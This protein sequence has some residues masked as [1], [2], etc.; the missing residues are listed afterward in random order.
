MPESYDVQVAHPRPQR[1]SMGTI[2]ELSKAADI[3]S[4]DVE[5]DDRFAGKGESP[6]P[7]RL[8]SPVKLVSDSVEGR[9]LEDQPS[10]G[11][12]ASG[13]EKI[14]NK[15]C[16][17]IKSSSPGRIGYHGKNGTTGKKKRQP[18]VLAPTGIRYPAPI[19]TKIRLPPLLSEQSKKASIEKLK[20]P[21]AI[22]EKPSSRPEEEF[23]ILS[24]P[25]ILA[26]PCEVKVEDK[27]EEKLVIEGDGISERIV[28][29][30]PGL[31]LRF[32]NPHQN[33]DSMLD[34]IPE[35][36][37]SAEEQIVQEAI[38]NP[39]SLLHELE[40]RKA[41]LKARA[42][43]GGGGTTTLLDLDDVA[44]RGNEHRR[45]MVNQFGADGAKEVGQGE[46]DVP[47]SVVY[48]RA[49]EDRKREVAKKRV[50]GRDA[51]TKLDFGADSGGM[52]S[53][54]FVPDQTSSH[55][56]SQVQ[57]PNA[58]KKVY[59]QSH[60]EQELGRNTPSAIGVP[61]INNG[62]EIGWRRVSSGSDRGLITPIAMVR[63]NS[64][65]FTTQNDAARHSQVNM[66]NSA[67]QSGQMNQG[68]PSS[69]YSENRPMSMYSAGYATSVNTQSG[70]AQSGYNRGTGYLR[71]SISE[72]QKQKQE[73]PIQA[74]QTSDSRTSM[75]NSEQA[76][77]RRMMIMAGHPEQPVQA[78][79]V[80]HGVPM[81]TKQG[82][83]LLQRKQ[84]SDTRTRKPQW[85]PTPPVGMVGSIAPI[86]PESRFG[87][88]V[89][90]GA[91]TAKV[92]MKDNT[93]K[94]EVVERWRQSVLF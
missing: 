31:G 75:M 47:L 61:S 68:R 30:K 89:G 3:D 51:Q 69:M 5:S 93:R 29:M 59:L 85:Y 86:G 70:Y 20:Q 60:S 39:N 34:K 25:M 72:S 84:N 33:L 18:V 15:P 88:G 79:Q 12:E 94:K 44:L 24:A 16:S 67:S 43:G 23:S 74:R 58:G 91:A 46:D 8:A 41:L 81:M 19:P 36:K 64:V 76:N 11:L 21:P 17:P 6:F 35:K 52:I 27:S 22:T 87:T 14:S 48:E 77:S 49:V 28:N 92:M 63:P 73:D 90:P 9:R 45:K 32:E 26:E 4:G 57:N 55:P 71:A 40:E 83:E 82:I 42:R 50:P 62:H 65:V 54:R 2:S 80:G 78:G 37:P 66:M 38:E 56:Q 1:L 7:A 13:G 10:G 53:A